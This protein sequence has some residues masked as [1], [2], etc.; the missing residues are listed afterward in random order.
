MGGI[1]GGNCLGGMNFGNVLC[2]GRWEMKQ[3]GKLGSNLG[4][5]LKVRLTDLNF[6]LVVLDSM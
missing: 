1:R 5:A 4:R 3:E 6:I 2:K